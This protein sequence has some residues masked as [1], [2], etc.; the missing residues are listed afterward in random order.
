VLFD[1]VAVI[2]SDEGAKAMSMDNAATYFVRDAFGHLKAIAVDKSGQ[3]P[4][5]M[6]SVGHHAG[7]LG[8]NDTDAF[9]A[10]AKTRQWEREKF[11]RTMA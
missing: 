1:A 3:A 10:A 5:K 7:V 9:V 4:L 8:S 11:V 2:F 6:A